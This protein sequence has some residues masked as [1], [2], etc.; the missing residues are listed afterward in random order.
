MAL[1][2]AVASR[3]AY[4]QARFG[5]GVLSPRGWYCF[6]T[7]GSNG[8]N[9]FVS[10]NPIGAAELFSAQWPGFAGPAIQLSN[11]SGDTSGRF[12]VARTIARVFPVHRSF[13]QDVIA[14]R[15]QPASDFPFGPYPG[16]QLTYR[17]SELVEYRT[18]ANTEGL[19]TAS[20]L[21]RNG[22][23]ITGVALLNGQELNLTILHVRLPVSAAGLVPLIIQQVERDHAPHQP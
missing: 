14:E 17:S 22:D 3:L 9:L 2:P 13:V 16:D 23:P 21:I 20:R 18:P 7:Y 10:P 4:Y 12:S 11:V 19:G 8:S 1:S 15:I 6:G 5:P